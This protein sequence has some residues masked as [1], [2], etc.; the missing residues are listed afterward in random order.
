MIEQVTFYLDARGGRHHSPKAAAQAD[1]EA[2][3]KSCREA[4]V[5]D[6]YMR[7]NEMPS[8]YSS[9]DEIDQ[10]LDRAFAHLREIRGAT[11]RYRRALI[12]KA[13]PNEQ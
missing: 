3:L 5:Q 11:H 7:R 4:L 1:I 10:W 12:Q 9:P 13:T 6:P 8:Q 2:A